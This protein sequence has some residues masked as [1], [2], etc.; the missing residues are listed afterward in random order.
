MLKKI[1]NIIILLITLAILVFVGIWLYDWYRKY[2]TDKTNQQLEY[3]MQDTIDY[4]DA[5]VQQ[6]AQENEDVVIEQA[7]ETENT[8]NTSTTTNKPKKKKVVTEIQYNDYVII[9][10]IVISKINLSYPILGESTVGSLK[11]GITKQYGVDPNRMGTM[12]LAGHNYRNGTMFSNLKKMVAG[13]IVEITDLSGATVQY[14]IDE[15]YETTPEDTAHLVQDTTT[16]R[17]VLTTCTN[18][19]KKRII[20]KCQAVD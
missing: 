14:I 4:F 17:L 15:I 10:K 12:V 18:D 3:V 2:E 5:Y 11:V 9:G 16:R 7:P 1:L 6:I 20:I 19:S 8:E 13:D